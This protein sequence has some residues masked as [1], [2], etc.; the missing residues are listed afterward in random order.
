M[1]S[2]K[3]LCSQMKR[4][5][6][7]IEK[8][9]L[10]K[11]HVVFYFSELANGSIFHKRLHRRYDIGEYEILHFGSMENQQHQFRVCALLGRSHFFVELPSRLAAKLFKA[12]TFICAVCTGLHIFIY[13]RFGHY[14][15]FP[16]LAFHHIFEWR[17]L[18]TR[19]SNPEFISLPVAP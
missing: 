7:R 13:T 15:N 18:A 5:Y 11:G 19:L 1:R 16:C 14:Q 4:N 9:P 17:C 10:K 3:S 12:A 8:K 2:R 6:Y